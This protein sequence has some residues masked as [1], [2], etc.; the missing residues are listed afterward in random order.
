MAQAEMLYVNLISVST[1]FRKVSLLITGVFKIA[2]W[3]GLFS[4]NGDLS[5]TEELDAIHDNEKKW[6]AWSKIECVKR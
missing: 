1:S 3:H 2:Q 5:V 4:M 6:Y